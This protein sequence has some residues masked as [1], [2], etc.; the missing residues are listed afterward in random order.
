MDDDDDSVGWGRPRPKFSE[1][2]PSTPDHSD[3]EDDWQ[4][5]VD[6]MDDRAGRPRP[7][8]RSSVFAADN[9]P[10][11]TSRVAPLI[12]FPLHPYEGAP[13]GELNQTYVNQGC[14]ASLKNN[15]YTSWDNGKTSPHT[16]YSCIFTCP[17]TG[18]HF[19]AGNWE[20]EKAVTIIDGV[21]WYPT[22]K[23]A[24][25]A[26][27]AR[28]LDC[29]SHRRCHGT[30]KVLYPR[31]IYGSLDSP[32]LSAGDAP[33]LP[34]LP[35][36]VVLPISFSH[37]GGGN[38]DDA[39]LPPKQALNEWYDSFSKK[40]DLA[41][42]VMDGGIGPQK[43]CYIALS[44]QESSPKTLFTAIFTCHL[45]GERFASGTLVGQEAH[46]ED[47]WYLDCETGTVIPRDA[48]VEDDD[49]ELDRLGL[50]KIHFIWYK[51]KKQAINA[52]AGR[53]VDCLR[54]R[55]SHDDIVS[56][57]RYCR[58]L[59]Y[60]FE[61]SPEIWKL[62]SESAQRVG[63]AECLTL[64]YEDRLTT[65]FGVTDLHCFLEEEHDA[66]YWRARYRKARKAEI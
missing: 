14:T 11:S 18:E 60:S 42:I 59:P 17:V 38:Q 58:E 47:Y 31:C 1:L 36:G 12:D 20:N 61:H 40:L 65:Q 43:E 66:E 15:Y 10:E 22:K 24:M 64:P 54:H 33:K 55:G 50:Q 57:K 5:D 13:C 45:T 32:Y 44:N 27:A 6:M 62:V 41:G 35:P 56:D 39:V 34:V 49:N 63:D 46:H 16:L 26:A 51:T 7:F 4:M 25:I 2:L 21:C 53:A 19:A 28:A 37:G 3:G 30:E 23:I 9:A 48:S 8:S 52:A 29:F